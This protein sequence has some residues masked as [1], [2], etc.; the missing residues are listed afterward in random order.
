MIA[1]EPNVW[2]PDEQA[3]P[4][5]GTDAEKLAFLLHY[6]ILAPSRLNAQPWQFKVADGCVELHADRMRAQ[7][8]GDPDDRSMIMGCGAALLNLHAAIRAFGFAGEVDLMPDRANS[9]LLARVRLG[10]P[11]EPGVYERA[12]FRAITERATHRQPFEDRPVPAMM[13]A[14][15]LAA[16][17]E[18][19]ARLHIVENRHARAAVADLVAQSLVQLLGD[20]SYR[21][22][23]AAWIHPGHSASRDGLPEPV[24]G[25]GKLLDLGA[26]VLDFVL[27]GW[28]FEH[29]VA[30]RDRKLLQEAPVLALLETE[31]DT[32]AAWLMAGQALENVLLYA[33]AQGLAASIVSEPVELPDVRAKLRDAAGCKG[34]PQLLLRIGCHRETL[35]TPRRMVGEVLISA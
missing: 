14:S 18:L 28:D 8:M 33:C 35:H 29:R 10:S 19:G 24:H 16:A 12:V 7:P 11:R 9:D 25:F 21:R 2:E 22:E 4:T 30:A 26:S 31:E 6:A 23:L 34:I 27:H 15:L 1:A 13:V 3:F 32:P 5:D 17:E 20:K